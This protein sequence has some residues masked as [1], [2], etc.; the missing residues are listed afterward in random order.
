ME[1]RATLDEG[2]KFRLHWDSYLGRLTSSCVT[3]IHR[4][5]FELFD[6]SEP[7]VHQT[8]SLIQKVTSRFIPPVQTGRGPTHPPE[9]RVPA[10]SRG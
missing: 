1:P 6:R 9:K 7:A 5:V 4:N 10:I 8:A 3:K 2:G